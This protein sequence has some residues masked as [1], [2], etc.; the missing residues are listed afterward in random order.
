MA[1]DK[2][3]VDVVTQRLL[4]ISRRVS[5]LFSVS[6]KRASISD[7]KPDIH[8]VRDD[9]NSAPLREISRRKSKVD[10]DCA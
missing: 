8:G 3:L 9:E 4:H 1:G 6:F 7:D 5:L 2:S 10:Y